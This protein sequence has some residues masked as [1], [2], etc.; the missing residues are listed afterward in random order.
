M[1][2]YPL[3][4]SVMQKITGTKICKRKDQAM[5]GSEGTFN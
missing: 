3:K 1:E 2:N 4:L 5:D